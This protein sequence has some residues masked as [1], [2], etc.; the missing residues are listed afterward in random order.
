MVEIEVHG[1]GGVMLRAML[2][3]MVLNLTEEEAKSVVTEAGE[4]EASMHL[5][6]KI[7]FPSML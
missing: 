2:T 4:V 3:A 6:V 1:V 7:L 5:R